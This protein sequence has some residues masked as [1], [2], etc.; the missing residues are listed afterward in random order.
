ME[1]T[2]IN[3]RRIIIKIKKALDLGSLVHTKVLLTSTEHK[4]AVSWCAPGLV[5]FL[6]PARTEGWRWIISFLI[7]N[8]ENRIKSHFYTLFISDILSYQAY[9]QFP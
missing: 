2:A 9:P 3:I 5:K 1:K 4:E 7:F 8:S 6:L